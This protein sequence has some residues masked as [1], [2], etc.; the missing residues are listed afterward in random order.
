MTNL[1]LVLSKDPHTT[2]TPDLVLDIGLDAKAKGNDVALYLIEDGIT[3]ARKSTF[4]DKLAAAQ[5]KGVK[6]FADDKAVLSRA[7]TGKL[8]DG[9]EI[10][11]ISTLL[12]FIMDDYDRVVWF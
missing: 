11:E 8:I 10:K 3:A 7:L 9:V 5:S 6:I 1:L 2:E 4:G 12:D